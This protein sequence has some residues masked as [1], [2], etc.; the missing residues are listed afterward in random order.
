MLAAIK[1]Q[2]Y[3]DADLKKA[4]KHMH[5]TVNYT[6][7]LE[8]NLMNT[9]TYMLNLTSILVCGW[10]KDFDRSLYPVVRVDS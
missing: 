2:K 1:C 4:E 10:I 8:N 5:V 7:A 3:V 6:L 9:P